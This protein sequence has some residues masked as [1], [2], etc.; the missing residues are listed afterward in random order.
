MLDTRLTIRF[1]K[2]NGQQIAS[3]LSTKT[4]KTIVFVPYPRT[5]TRLYNLEL[6][7]SDIWP[8]LVFLDKRGTVTINGIEFRTFRKIQLE[9][10]SG[11][12]FS[13]RFHG[14]PA[15]DAVSKLAFLSQLKLRIS[16]GNPTNRVSLDLTEM[17][18]SEIL[19]EMSA[20]ANV[21]IKV[22]NK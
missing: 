8:A 19:K 5:A 17:T 15:R 7:N 3:V 6:K 22:S 2:N 4:G 12:K 18:L 21:K 10:K 20:N 11:R 14:M 13:V 16:S 9:M 1:V